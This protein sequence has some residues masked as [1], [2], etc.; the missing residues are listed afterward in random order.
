MHPSPLFNLP[1]KH[2]VLESNV[3]QMSSKL[4][5]SDTLQERV[6]TLDVKQMDPQPL[7]AQLRETEKNSK[8]MQE[9]L[10]LQLK[11]LNENLGQSNLCLESERQFTQN[12][13]TLIK[14]LTAQLREIEQQVTRAND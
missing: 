2:Q 14:N 5:I 4:V 11:Q 7:K 10:E 12:A 8:E 1:N 3:N 6:A 9:Q 13:A